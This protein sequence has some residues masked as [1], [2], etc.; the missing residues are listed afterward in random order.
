MLRRFM[1]HSCLGGQGVFLEG[2]S[3]W[4]WLELEMGWDVWCFILG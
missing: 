3:G 1:G 4:D 2:E